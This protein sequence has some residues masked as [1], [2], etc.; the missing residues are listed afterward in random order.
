MP[1][2]LAAAALSGGDAIERA[3]LLARTLDIDVS[4]YYVHARLVAV[5]NLGLITP[6][7][8]IFPSFRRSIL[9]LAEVEQ[10]HQLI[11]FQV[12]VFTGGIA[13]V[14]LLSAASPLLVPLVAPSIV[15][16]RTLMLMLAL[17]ALMKGLGTVFGIGLYSSGGS[18]KVLIGALASIL[19]GSLIGYSLLG[20]SATRG[21][22]I[23]SLVSGVVYVLWIATNSMK[24]RRIG[25]SVPALSWMIALPCVVLIYVL[26]KGSQ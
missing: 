18:K 4:N 9:D 20:W 1:I 25:V 10:H 12:L 22:G 8:L 5:L 11:I 17:G 6:V 13:L 21:M 3:I 2:A 19:L 7:A 15:P 23:G 14:F 24:I 26:I 16:D